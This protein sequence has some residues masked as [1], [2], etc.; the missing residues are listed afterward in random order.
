[1]NNQLEALLEI[2]KHGAV[3]IRGVSFQILFGLWQA[4]QLYEDDCWF[5]AVGLERFED[6]D[7][8]PKSLLL[9][10]T[11]SNHYY[12][13]KTCEGVYF[14]SNMVKPLR[15]FI[16]ILQ[17]DPDARLTLVFNFTPSGEVG[18]MA[19]FQNQKAADKKKI[20]AKFWKLCQQAGQASDGGKNP[21]LNVKERDA[22]I[23]L[24]RLQFV[25]HS[26]DGLQKNI[27]K[28]MAKHFGI[29]GERT[30]EFLAIF[31][32]RFT[33][34][35]RERKRVERADMD[36]VRDNIGSNAS[37]EREFAARGS[38]L[39][40]V[41]WNVD[42]QP[43]DFR[44]GKRTR[45]GHIAADLDVV[46]PRW[47]KEIGTAF[48]SQGIVVVRASSGQGKSTLALRFA[49]DNWSPA[50]TL[51]LQSAR[52]QEE[53]ELVCE[54][55]R[56]RK[57]TLQLPTF[58]LIDNASRRT[59]HWARVAQECAQLGIPTLVTLRQEDWIRFG[60]ETLFTSAPIQ[61]T[62]ELSEAREIF[63]S[64][65]NAGRVHP[66]VH[67]FEWAWE[68]VDEPRLLMEFIYLVTHGK[69]LEDR[70]REQLAEI[71]Q[72][73]SPLKLEIL[74]RVVMA[75]AL[76]A[77]LDEARLFDDLKCEWGPAA[78][79]PGSGALLA[80]L[81]GEYLQRINSRLTGLHWVRSDHLVNLLHDGYPTV[82]QTAL[83]VLNIMAPENL[84]DAVASALLRSDIN[85]QDFTDGLVERAR[86]APLTGVLAFVEG[87]FEAGEFDFFNAN[88]SLFDEGFALVG[89]SG[90]FLLSCDWAPS[91]NK[92]FLQNVATIMSDAPNTNIQKLAKISH[93]FRQVSRGKELCAQFLQRATPT[94]L[95]DKLIP[96]FGATGDLLAWL[97]WCGIPFPQLA[98]MKS[99]LFERALS[100]DYPIEILCR[101]H[102]GLWLF[103]RDVYR[104]WITIAP[105]EMRDYAQWQ[106]ECLHLQWDAPSDDLQ[107]G[108]NARGTVELNY[109][110][111]DFQKANS[112]SVDRIGKLHSLF[113]FYAHY[114]A[115]AVWPSL[116]PI[117]HDSSL[118][119]MTQDYQYLEFV[120]ARNSTWNRLIETRFEISTFYDFQK[121]WHEARQR[122][123][124]VLGALSTRI[125]KLLSG[126][127]PDLLITSDWASDIQIFQDALVQTPKTP[128]KTPQE[129]KEKLKI[130][131]EWNSHMSAW[132]S[133][134]ITTAVFFQE[135]GRLPC[136][137]SEDSPGE[138]ASQAAHLALYNLR[139]AAKDLVGMQDSM[140]D[141]FDFT[142][143]TFKTRDLEVK[144]RDIFERVLKAL[145]VWIE[146]RPVSRVSDL[147]SFLMRKRER[148]R[149]ELSERL[150]VALTELQEQGMRFDYPSDICKE[151]PLTYLPIM[152]EVSDPCNFTNERDAVLL[153]LAPLHDIADFGCL[154]PTF[155]KRRFL[156]EGFRAALRLPAEDDEDGWK[157][158]ESVLL[159]T[160]EL[161]AEV[162]AL[163]PEL[164][165]QE[166]P[167]LTL[168]ATL[169][170]LL[171]AL[172]IFSEQRQTIDTLA[173]ALGPFTKRLFLQH[174][175]RL[176][177]QPLT[178]EVDF[179]R[180][181]TLL[182][183]GCGQ[184]A[185]TSQYKFVEKLLT[186]SSS[187][188]QAQ[189]QLR[190]AEQE[191]SPSF[192]L[193]ADLDQGR[194]TL[195]VSA[196]EFVSL[197]YDLAHESIFR[198][199]L[200]GGL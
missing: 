85:K 10:G 65:H 132:L 200:E 36:E 154:I 53:A 166:H 43:V 64:L 141:L 12:Q 70:L 134:F 197:D 171:L 198:L 165:L 61:P 172:Q 153:A 151:F 99:S 121:A 180:M 55:L 117:S 40:F 47:L 42:E 45:A 89:Q 114:N 185:Q 97:G 118:K 125:E 106:L 83:S 159:D 38:L 127:L 87:I 100:W 60:S 150:R 74:R 71:R 79:A 189:S 173:D 158:R 104:E 73:E 128:N 59:E 37:F 161:P 122:M 78:V 51:T 67:S 186:A 48:E 139:D 133:A 32:Y 57:Q 137:R 112:A 9:S 155:E 105:E 190:E 62:L 68:K 39:K 21:D 13:A 111:E 183:E 108:E 7:I 119:R 84:S 143:D 14:P 188:A 107:D 75:D 192:D 98:Q 19:N 152:F 176:L 41:N 175:N 76:G 96:G 17:A 23:L 131:A 109:L 94:I 44:E 81:D 116:L 33:L 50:H 129:V 160:L 170:A 177:S 130:A 8:H 148:H 194:E 56:H 1:M 157:T 174:R 90:P 15:S 91:H 135:N 162:W 149:S 25:T 24:D 20:R 124:T 146:D 49:H 184:H 195:W 27:E 168:K 140:S 142:G 88:R 156:P 196:E 72:H 103:D 120:V 102:E 77:P 193:L 110:G 18:K 86:S 6:V 182:N 28:L 145:E 34:W 191:P 66:I 199:T 123:V 54:A 52:S 144:E 82:T 95:E 29:A 30:G 136:D 181:K 187:W 113:P 58:L 80:P 26:V 138:D 178:G 35:S 5:E 169:H 93:K 3:N 126:A 69:M 63:R 4:M 92:K 16:E 46:R 31:F 179:D 167:P 11:Q 115:N 101:W 22:E 147:D 163:L 164:P 2:R